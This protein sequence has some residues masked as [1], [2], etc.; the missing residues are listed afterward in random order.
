[1]GLI[2]QKVQERISPGEVSLSKDDLSK[3]GTSLSTA[4]R[5][6]WN[7]KFVWK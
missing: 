4:N 6:T 7:V 1:M 5:A 3:R 2:K